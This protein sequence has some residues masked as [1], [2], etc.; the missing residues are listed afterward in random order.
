MNAYLFPIQSAILAFIVLAFA[1]T[2]PYLAYKYYK[3]GSLP[4]L[5]GLLEGS[6][7]FYMIAAFFLTLLPLPTHEFV[8]SLTTAKVQL[9]PFQFIRDFFRDTVL[10]LSDTSTYFPALKQ[11]VVIQPLFNIIMTI[12]FGFYLRYYFKKSWKFTLLASLGLSLFYEVTQL[13]G[14]YGYYSRSYRLFDVDDLFLNT[15][16]GLLGYAMTPLFG[17]FFPSRD[18][19]DKSITN[20]AKTV[21]WLRRLTAYLIDTGVLSGLVSLVSLELLSGPIL[22]SI[23]MWIVIAFWMAS[24]QGSSL[25][26]R[27]VGLRVVKGDGSKL[28]LH[29][30]LKR[31]LLYAGFVHVAFIILTRGFDYL[32]TYAYDNVEVITFYLILMFGY[33]LILFGHFLWVIVSGKKQFFYESLSKTKI[34]SIYR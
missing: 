27:I 19:L 20:K 7:V 24:T 2:I 32:N 34:E 5:Q 30:T 21:T 25:G 8:D 15:M 16:G 6:F 31:N 17:V 23:A 33:I 10:V 14:I 11:G 3:Q 12:P 13:T 1:I 22:N 29:D 28:T 26:L 9:L 4:F 18:S